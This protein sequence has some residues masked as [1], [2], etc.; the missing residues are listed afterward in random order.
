MT[1]LGDRIRALR[2]QAGYTQSEFIN[3]LKK[4]Y[5]LKADRVMLSKWECS[6]QSPHIETLKC[7]ANALGVSLDYLNGVE[8]KPSVK[9]KNISTLN[10]TQIPMYGK[11]ACGNPIECNKCF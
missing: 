7:I 3:I 11:I 5:N 8:E 10:E 6:K 4:Q 2:K 1:T 9:L